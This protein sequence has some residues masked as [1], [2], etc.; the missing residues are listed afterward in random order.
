MTIYDLSTQ[1]R[2]VNDPSPILF[3]WPV[4]GESL[5]VQ[6]AFDNVNFDDIIGTVTEVTN[7]ASLPR[8]RIAYADADRPDTPTIITY[9]VTGA[10]HTGY[11]ELHITPEVPTVVSSVANTSDLSSLASSLGP[12]RM[13]TKD[14][15]VEAHDPEKLQRLVERR[16]SK[17][18]A[19][20]QFK[21]NVARPKNGG[22]CP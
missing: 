22:C 11:L 2:A 1:T 13:K 10:T 4:A 14:T 20:S 19:M 12:R 16:S 3:D 7:D 5:D 18:V 17:S 21:F 9:K 8:Y 15:E 6:V